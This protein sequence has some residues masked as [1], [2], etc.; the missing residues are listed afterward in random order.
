MWSVIQV[1]HLNT[2]KKKRGLHFSNI[3]KHIMLHFAY[4]GLLNFYP[5]TLNDLIEANDN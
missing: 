4:F 5:L 3:F 2:Q 1:I